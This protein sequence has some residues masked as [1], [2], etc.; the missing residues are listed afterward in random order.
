VPF[1]QAFRITVGTGVVSSAESNVGNRLSHGRHSTVYSY[2]VSLRY[3]EVASQ[4]SGLVQKLTS[5]VTGQPMDDDYLFDDGTAYADDATHRHHDQPR[6]QQA[7]GSH[8]THGYADAPVYE[9][10]APPAAPRR[11]MKVLPHPGAQAATYVVVVE[12][13]AYEEALEIIDH[14]K[15]RKAV[16]LNM[17]LLDTA[18]S[19]R[20]VDFLHGATNALEGHQQKIGSGVFLFTPSAMHIVTQGGM[21][22]SLHLADA[23]WNTP[24]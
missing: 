2:L 10:D 13:R 6:S 9:D 16:I 4:M 15:V 8:R 14:L 18:Q 11:S 19:Q 7:A 12:P 22:Q 24:R 17:H 20:V 3:N 21:E 23:Y 1:K 5:W